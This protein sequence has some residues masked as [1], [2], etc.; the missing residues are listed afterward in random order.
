ME[1]ETNVPSLN[2]VTPGT[3]EEGT[4][5][6]SLAQHPTSHIKLRLTAGYANNKNLLSC[7][8]VCTSRTHIP[9]M[10]ELSGSL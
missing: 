4:P 10:P 9:L 1:E 6:P 5:L 2:L 7:N 8:T 3:Q